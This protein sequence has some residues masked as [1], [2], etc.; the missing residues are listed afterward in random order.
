MKLYEYLV[1]EGFS[2]SYTDA[3][4]DMVTGRVLL[5]EEKTDMYRELEI[6]ESYTISIRKPGEPVSFMR[7]FVH[8]QN[9]GG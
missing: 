8:D 4:L 5:N 3:I 9:K 7:A 1:Q 2:D 6:G